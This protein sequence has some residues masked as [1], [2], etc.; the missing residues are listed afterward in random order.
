MKHVGVRWQLKTITFVV[1]FYSY[2]YITAISLTDLTFFLKST[3]EIDT[4]VSGKKRS[5]WDFEIKK[6]PWIVGKSLTE[7]NWN[8]DHHIHWKTCDTVTDFELEKQS[9]KYDEFLV[10]QIPV[11]SLRLR[12]PVSGFKKG[13]FLSKERNASSW[14]RPCVCSQ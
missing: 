3:S 14:Y 11:H 2:G 13:K 8:I 9:I 6:K 7:N 4:R 5:K 1:Y 10:E 12:R